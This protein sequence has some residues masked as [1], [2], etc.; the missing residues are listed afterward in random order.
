MAC[1]AT[2]LQSSLS[3]NTR[4][5]INAL[6]AAILVRN[7]NWKL[8]WVSS[9]SF[10]RTYASDLLHRIAHHR[11]RTADNRLNTASPRPHAVFS[12]ADS[13]QEP[14]RTQLCWQYTQSSSKHNT[15]CPRCSKF[16]ESTIQAAGAD[17]QQPST[18]CRSSCL[19]SHSYLSAIVSITASRTLAILDGTTRLSW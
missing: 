9:W 7:H 18:L 5:H 13:A 11:R 10:Q 1:P 2:K 6:L 16:R 12:H 8:L 3:I 17:Q 14:V 19:S 15:Y 4:H